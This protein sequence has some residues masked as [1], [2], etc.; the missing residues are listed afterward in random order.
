MVLAKYI[1]KQQFLHL[2]HKLMKYLPIIIL[3]ILCNTNLFA[4]VLLPDAKGTK[5]T[6]DTSKWSLSGGNTI[7]KSTGN[8]GIGISAPIYKLDINNSSNPIRIQ[9]LSGGNLLTDSIMVITVSGVVKRVNSNLFSKTDSTTASNGLSLTGKDIRLGGTL[10]QS[11]TLTQNSNTF[12]IATGGSGFNITGLTNGTTSDSLVTVL[13]G[14]VKKIG[15]T[16]FSKTDSTTASNGLSLTGKDIRL[17]GAL[18]QSTTLTQNSNAFTIATGGSSFNITGLTNGTTSDSLVTVLNGSVK[19]IVNTYNPSIM[20]VYSNTLSNLSTTYTA[21]QF[22]IQTIVDPN[23]TISGNTNVTLLTAGTYRISYTVK[24]TVYATSG[25]SY[26]VCDYYLNKNGSSILGSNGSFTLQ[27]SNLKTSSI[28]IEIIGYFN[29]ND[30]IKL[31]GKAS[32]NSVIRQSP[33]G[34]SLRIEKIRP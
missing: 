24:D 4:Q 2:L 33:Y 15:S 14:S 21:V 30:V 1:D 25:T 6:V 17:G 31:Y 22:N 23:Y 18:T 9:T 8:V 12:T 34:V 29:Q 13:N 11:T 28:T 19:K 27:R 26:Y 10:T 16:L 3:L 5:L 7:L 20:S 32:S